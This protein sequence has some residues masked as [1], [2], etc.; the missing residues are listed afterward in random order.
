M[1]LSF[2]PCAARVRLSSDVNEIKL[3]F[4]LPP[5]RPTPNI[6][7]NWDVAPTDPLPVVRSLPSF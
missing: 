7:P 4:S 3:V 1:T 2:A 5:Q 6:A